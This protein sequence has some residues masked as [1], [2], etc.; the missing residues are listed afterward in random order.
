MCSIIFMKALAKT[1]YN[2]L[3]ED[4]KNYFIGN[5][6]QNICTYSQEAENSIIKLMAE[7]LNLKINI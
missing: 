1:A 7:I 6:L 3:Y 2:L 4:L 5:E